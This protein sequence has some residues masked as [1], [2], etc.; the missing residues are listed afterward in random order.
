MER[1]GSYFSNLNTYSDPQVEYVY[2]L[3][4]GASNNDTWASTNSSFGGTYDLEC[5]GSGTLILPSTSYNALLVRVHMV[6]AFID[7]FAYFWYSSDNGAILIMYTAGDGG[8][9]PPTGYYLSSL[10]IGIEENQFISD[11]RYN[12]PV[13]NH[14]NLSFQ[15]KNSSEHQYIVLNSLGQEVFA[16]NTKPNA[17]Y[18]ETVDLDF[19]T[20]PSGMYF[21]SIRSKETAH[22]AKSIKII[23][24]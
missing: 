3:E 17:G 23:K 5:I 21:F 13:S 15:S 1:V 19:S 2:P 4:L 14:F 12:N 8:F 20:Y 18:K 9:I 7:Y 24:Q 11:L 6:E 16:G 10:T 22:I